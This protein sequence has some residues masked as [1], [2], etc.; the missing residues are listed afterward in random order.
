MVKYWLCAENISHEM[1]L[2]PY[3]NVIWNTLTL[4]IFTMTQQYCRILAFHWKYLEWTANNIEMF[5]SHCK[6]WQWSGG[7]FLPNI[8]V[9]LEICKHSNFGVIFHSNVANIIQDIVTIYP[10]NLVLRTY[11]RKRNWHFSNPLLLI[12]YVNLK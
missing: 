1:L 4:K 3:W 2:Q 9:I 6:Y 10:R 11:S 7:I 12:I 8:A 5:I